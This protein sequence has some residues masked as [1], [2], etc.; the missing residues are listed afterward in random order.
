M[1]ALSGGGV[2]GYAARVIGSLFGERARSG[3]MKVKSSNRLAI[4]SR[5]R[6]PTARSSPP[7]SSAVCRDAPSATIRPRTPGLTARACPLRSRQARDAGDRLRPVRM[8]TALISVQ[9]VTDSAMSKSPAD[10]AEFPLTAGRPMPGVSLRVVGPAARADQPCGEVGQLAIL[11]PMNMD[12]YAGA[13]ADF[14]HHD[15]H[16][17]VLTS[18]YGRMDEHGRRGTRAAGRRPGSRRARRSRRSRNWP[19]TK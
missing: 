18:R 6:R 9:C 19:L 1:S 5:L 16:A 10:L 12:G 11:S 17:C 8:Q 3:S 14:L 13:T 4:S 2:V 15:G 7:I